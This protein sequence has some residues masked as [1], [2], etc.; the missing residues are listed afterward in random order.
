MSRWHASSCTDPDVVLVPGEQTDSR[1]GKHLVPRC[2]SCDSTPD[3]ESLFLQQKSSHGIP[4]L[5]PDEPAGQ[6]N[7]WYPKCVRYGQPINPKI[8]D[9]IEYDAFR[10]SYL[11]PTSKSSPPL[12]V[13]PVY[14][15][16]L[17][18]NEIRLICLDSVPPAETR[19]TSPVHINLE[20]YPRDRCP[21]YEAA[22]YSWGGE[23]GDYT[24]RSPIYIGKSWDVL[25]QTQ[26]CWNLLQRLWLKE[27]GARSVWV[28]AICINQEDLEERS[29]Q[30]GMMALTYTR[31]SRVF[32]YL[33]E[34]KS[35]GPVASVPRYLYLADVFGKTE[36]SD[37]TPP[38]FQLPGALSLTY[39]SRIWIIP[40][41]ILAPTALFR[42]GNEEFLALPRVF[43]E[44]EANR[45]WEWDKTQAEW[46]KFLGKGSMDHVSLFELLQMTTNSRSSD[47]RDRLFAVFP[48]LSGE[49]AR[50]FLI[51]DYKLSAKHAIIGVASFC[52]LNLREPNILTAA[53]GLAGGDEDVTWRP[54]LD[55][56]HDKAEVRETLRQQIS[57]KVRGSLVLCNMPAAEAWNNNATIDPMTG[58]LSIYMVKVLEIRSR[59][60]PLFNHDGCHAYE[61]HKGDWILVLVTRCANLD[62]LIIPGQDRLFMMSEGDTGSNGHIY[63]ILRETDDPDTFKLLTTCY[64]VYFAGDD[65]DVPAESKPRDLIT[66]VL[67]L[68]AMNQAF[69]G[70]KTT[71]ILH[72]AVWIC[73]RMLERRSRSRFVADYLKCIPP[74]LQPRIRGKYVEFSLGGIGNGRFYSEFRSLC[75]K[76]VDRA[77]EGGTNTG[78]YSGLDVKLRLEDSDGEWMSWWEFM[79]E[80]LRNSHLRNQ[81]VTVSVDVDDLRDFFEVFLS[82]VQRY[83]HTPVK[84]PGMVDG[85]KMFLGGVTN[86][87]Y[88]SDRASLNGYR[89][90]IWL[91]EENH[92]DALDLKSFV[93]EAGLMGNPKWPKSLMQ[94]FRINGSTRRLTIL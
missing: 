26:S 66:R 63:L 71:Q 1:F 51:P 70:Q 22:S 2:R 42:Y 84:Y 31:C 80:V 93:D 44:L 49:G 81:R 32:A 36:D 5:P 78:L 43:Q 41:L 10:S 40:E 24:K 60:K 6:L 72:N 69:L 46:L 67:P 55:R 54:G 53:R 16:R 39:F 4:T 17:S 68:P 62:E 58:A 9:R 79:L 64:D 34:G 89:R 8:L 83:D 73:S 91:A 27:R 14:P 30:V 20:V 52:L 86:D 33:G 57:R 74:E 21:E 94:A 35:N 85:A 48:L 82:K 11:E 45:D 12:S 38:G 87:K 47:P 92:L 13:S 50:R 25:W 77:K 90:A 3:L 76:Y 59:P 75:A 65:G 19:P 29:T 15:T 7:L 23:N 18:P 28:D 56:L 37:E 88:W 61:I